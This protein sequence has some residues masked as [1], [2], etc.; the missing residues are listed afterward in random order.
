MLVTSIL[1]FSHNVFK[2]LP[3]QGR[4]NSG[5]CGKELINSAPKQQIFAC[6][7]ITKQYFHRNFLMCHN[8]VIELFVIKP[9]TTQYRILMHKRYTAVENIARKGEIA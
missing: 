3:S 1:S 7:T 2:W 9:I 6:S 5:L 4:Q 8:I